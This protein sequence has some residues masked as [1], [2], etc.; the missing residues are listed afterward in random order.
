MIYAYS[1][2]IGACSGSF[3]YAATWRY[4]REIDFVHGRSSCPTC[5]HKLAWYDLIPIISWIWLRGKCRYCKTSISITYMLYE[6]GIAI[7]A[8]LCA[9]AYGLTIE[10]ACV[11]IMIL[12]LISMAIIDRAT[13]VIPDGLQLLLII[14]I[15]ILTLISPEMSLT[16]HLL[17]AVSIS[18]FMALM[19]RLVRDSFGGGDVKLMYLCGWALGWRRIVLAA[20]IAVWT[21]GIYVIY[22]IFAKHV[23]RKTH[24]AFAPY[25]CAGIIFSLY[26]DHWF[27]L[28]L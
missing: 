15:G 13:M 10:A 19:N 11:F 6:L 25:L 21:A 26:A 14:P 7:A 12:I 2:M 28:M 8:L 20:L 16:H 1:F 24:I 22:L 17:G 18:G 5:H 9:F 3:L 23:Q 27:L 4:L